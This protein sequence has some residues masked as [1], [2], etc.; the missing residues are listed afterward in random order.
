MDIW[1]FFIQT[2][3]IRT[4]C[5]RTFPAPPYHLE[6]ANLVPF[7][8][9]KRGIQKSD[10][11]KKFHAISFRLIYAYFSQCF[12]WTDAYT[13]GQSQCDQTLELK[14]EQIFPKVAH[15]EALPVFYLKGDIFRN[16]TKMPPKNL[17]NLVRTLKNRPI[18]FHWDS[19]HTLT[20]VQD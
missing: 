20:P 4:I 18:R 6:A 12:A 2:F 14:V 11:L 16:G 8:R 10:P 7:F 13:Y 15:K 5:I 17:G 1:V 3:S 9:R 19:L